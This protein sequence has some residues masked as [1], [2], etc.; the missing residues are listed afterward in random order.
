MSIIKFT[1]RQKSP[2]AG[3]TREASAP[4]EGAVVVEFGNETEAPVVEAHNRGEGRGETEDI[5]ACFLADS[6]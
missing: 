4:D 6:Q 1:F 3:T 5:K 2:L